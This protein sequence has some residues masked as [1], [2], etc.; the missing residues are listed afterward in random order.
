VRI[1][2]D[3]VFT[4]VIVDTALGSALSFD[5]TRPLKGAAI[6]WSVDGRVDTGDSA[7]TPRVGPLAVPPWAVLTTLSAPNVQ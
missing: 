5:L 6:F 1:A 3:S 4:N 2:R 7:S